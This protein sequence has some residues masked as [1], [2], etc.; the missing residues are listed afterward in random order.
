MKTVKFLITI[1]LILLL[2]LGMAMTNPDKDDFVNWAV[3]EFQENSDSG[4]EALLG[5][6]IGRPVLTIATTREDYF[7]FSI[8]RVANTEEEAVFLGVFKKFF[9]FKE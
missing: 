2:A 1:V 6:V 7:I 8:Y 5:G 4:L 3:E 9:S